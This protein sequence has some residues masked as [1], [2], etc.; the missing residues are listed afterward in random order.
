V[1]PEGAAAEEEG[2]AIAGASA[3]CACAVSSHCPAQPSVSA[4]APASHRFF[5]ADAIK[6]GIRP[7]VTPWS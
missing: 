6:C 5:D 4:A 2:A 1:A 3:A 7:R